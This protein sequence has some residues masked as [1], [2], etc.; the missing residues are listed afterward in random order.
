VLALDEAGVVHARYPG[1]VYVRGNISY[2]KLDVNEQYLYVAG[3]SWLTRF[4]LGNPGSSSRIYT[5]NQVFDV[6]IMSSG[7]PSSSPPIASPRSRP[8]ASSCATSGLRS[9]IASWTPGVS[10]T[11]R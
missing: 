9:R 4:E 3:Q 10:S 8:R 11:T 7:N 5:E 6:E 1:N 2:G